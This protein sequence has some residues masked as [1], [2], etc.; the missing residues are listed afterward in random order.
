MV[1]NVVKI[2][3]KWV[4]DNSCIQYHKVIERIYPQYVIPCQRPRKKDFDFVLKMLKSHKDTP[5]IS[6]SL[7]PS[8]IWNWL[9]WS[10]MIVTF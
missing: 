1:W 10:L 8:M 5:Q 7:Y 3:Q 2:W 4:Y 9:G 6:I